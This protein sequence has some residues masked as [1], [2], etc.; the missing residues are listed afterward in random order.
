MFLLGVSTLLIILVLETYI[1]E[2][3]NILD[4]FQLINIKEDW[5]LPYLNIYP[6]GDLHV[7]S[8]NFSQSSWDRWIKMVM[9]DEYA[10]VVIVGDMLDNGLKNARTNSYEA[11]MQP[12]EQKQWLTQALRP[13]RD[14]IIGATTGNHEMRSGILADQ[15]PLYDVLAKLDLEYL[16]RKNMAFI[17]INLGRRTN[18]RQCSYT[19][20]LAHGASKTKSEK[21]SYAIDNMDIFVTGHV[22]QPNSA[23]R[24]KIVIDTKNEVV[25]MQDFVHITV[26]S[27]QKLGGYSLNAM[28]LGQ[29]STVFPIIKLSG[30]QKEVVVSWI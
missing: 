14:K 23:F 28:Y 6:I 29:S 2:M 24:S 3:S 16:Y 19:M 7:G 27:F 13:I 30:E 20:V 17:K 22:H 12:F 11:K 21:F 8:G 15:Y 25:R 9:E 4:D 18:D 5:E 1:K 26:P 10:R